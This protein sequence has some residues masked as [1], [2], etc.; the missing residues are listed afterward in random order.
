MPDKIFHFKTLL[1]SPVSL[2]MGSLF[3]WFSVKHIPSAMM[4][5]WLGLA[6]VLNLIS[7]V[8]KAWTKGEFTTALG[9]QKTVV[10][11]MVYSCTVIAMV[12]LVNMVQS[13]S[14]NTQFN[15]SIAIDSVMGFLVW[16]ELYSVFEN[17]SVIYPKSALTRF[18]ILPLLKV[19]R[20]RL[21][22]PPFP[23][24]KTEDDASDQHN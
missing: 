10:K 3:A 21:K 1:M 6:L 2:L 15:F 23:T 19:L 9:F 13:I 11:I 7:G 18:L 5:F 22:N 16:I 8:A 24:D 4:L 12:M 20:S 17:V 14:G